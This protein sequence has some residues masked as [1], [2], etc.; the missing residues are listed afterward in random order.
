[1]HADSSSDSSSSEDEGEEVVHV[2]CRT[3]RTSKRTYG[4]VAQDIEDM[5][6]RRR[7]KLLDE[8]LYLLRSITNSRATGKTCIILDAFKY[9]EELK[10]RVHQL[11][12]DLLAELETIS[13]R[14]IIDSQAEVKCE[15]R[16]PKVTVARL[17]KG[18]Q[19]HVSCEKRPGLLVGILEA[20]EALGLS[21]QQARVSCK[22]FF[23]FEAVSDEDKQLGRIVDPQHVKT[24]LMK[25]IENN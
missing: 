18:L 19:I 15:K 3:S 13:Q 25:I 16:A 8:N 14:Q 23:L 2:N 20:V 10:Q 5:V 6:R 21:V 22:D 24:T 12:R 17:E 1:M 7:K 4:L 9:I 11:N